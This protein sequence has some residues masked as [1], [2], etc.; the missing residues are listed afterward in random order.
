MCVARGRRVTTLIE[1][2]TRFNPLRTASPVLGTN[3][4]NILVV[5]PQNGTAV[6]KGIRPRKK[7]GKPGQKG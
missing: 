7:I 2:Q 5:C 6:V 1:Q 3:Y 4:L